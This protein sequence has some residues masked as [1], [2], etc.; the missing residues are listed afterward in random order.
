[1]DAQ[2][3]N[4]SATRRFLRM[5]RGEFIG[6]PVEIVESTD[7]TLQSVK[8]TVVDETLNMFQ[9]ELVDGGRTLQV[10]KANNV[11]EF[12]DGDGTPVRIPGDRIQY[13]PEDRIKRVR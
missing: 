10:A 2:T 11:F 12:P 8:G 6:L 5:A 9:L 1:M 3:T 4:E 7:P 13:R